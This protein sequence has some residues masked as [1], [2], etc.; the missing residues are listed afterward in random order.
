M[1]D[2]DQ[3]ETF[4]VLS[5][6]DGIIITENELSDFSDIDYEFENEL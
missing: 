4:E 6:V 2:L 3:R 5:R 1:L